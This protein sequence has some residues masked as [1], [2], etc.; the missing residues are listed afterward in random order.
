MKKSTITYITLCLL[1][2]TSV[3][4]IE[5]QTNETNSTNKTKIDATGKSLQGYVSSSPYEFPDLTGFEH[6]VG[7]TKLTKKTHLNT[8]TLTNEG[9]SWLMEAGSSIAFKLKNKDYIFKVNSLAEFNMTFTIEDVF[10][11][12]T[13]DRKENYTYDLDEDNEYDLILFYHKQ[14]PPQGRFADITFLP[15]T[16]KIDL[17]PNTENITK[18]PE[19][20][21][22]EVQE[23]NWFVEEIIIG[24]VIGLMILVFVYVILKK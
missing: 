20:V 24:A 15:T 8:G 11:K 2:L 13:I 12:E 3:T 18:E 19:V 23:T 1:V 22:N 16:E 10:S 6:P 7:K 14:Y 5:A 17:P 4:L 21:E 9:M